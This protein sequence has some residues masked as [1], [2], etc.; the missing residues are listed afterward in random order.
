M[1][2]SVENYSNQ[3]KIYELFEEYNS[4]LAA[5]GIR[6]IK[7]IEWSAR[8]LQFIRPQ[9]LSDISDENLLQQV[10]WNTFVG[11][12]LYAGLLH[13]LGTGDLNK[14]EETQQVITTLE[15]IVLDIIKYTEIGYV[16]SL[17][18][19]LQK[20]ENMKYARMDDAG[21]IYIYPEDAE[22]VLVDIQEVFDG[23]L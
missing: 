1:S 7:A 17:G 5:R 6:R 16:I 3:E 22:E 8:H 14:S 10:G 13:T 19:S 23:C 2:N 21:N 12:G 4:F 20:N 18:V 11:L 9:I 15:N